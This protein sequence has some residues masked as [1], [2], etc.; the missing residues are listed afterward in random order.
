[1]QKNV[2]TGWAAAHAFRD[3]VDAGFHGGGELAS[4]RLVA[5]EASDGLDGRK[6]VF[7]RLGGDDLDAQP[8]ARIA[9][10]ESRFPGPGLTT[11]RS[12]FSA[13]DGFDR[14]VHVAAD[15]GPGLRLGREVAKLCDTDHPIACT[16]REEDFGQR[17]REGDDALRDGGRRSGL[18]VRLRARKRGGQ[19]DR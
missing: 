2:R 15:L 10:A 1:M 12:G 8:G 5:G 16:H 6:R 7:E 14:R 19:R 18:G 3:G 13:S 4:L 11:T 9:S 17:R